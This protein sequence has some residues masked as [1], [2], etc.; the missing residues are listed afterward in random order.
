VTMHPRRIAGVLML[1]CT[2][3]LSGCTVSTDESDVR[4]I[5]SDIAQLL[6]PS[7]TPTPS[8]SAPLARTLV[9]WVRGNVY[10]RTPR[11]LPANSR[12]EQLDLALVELI[13]AGPRPTEAER[14]LESAIPP[15][16]T[17][18]GTVRG[19]RVVL[20]VPD[21]SQFEQGGVEEA[22]GQ[23]AIT[24]LSVPNVAS[25]RFTIDGAGTTV[26]VPDDR[27]SQ[28]VVTL[29]DYRTVLRN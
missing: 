1:T 3:A 24:A 29:A 28:R 8:E 27:R 12:Q 11:L 26:P 19:D 20:D 13:V 2:L 10:V 7:A 6:T 15:G 21:D 25:V 5:D 17:V 9:T 23:L 16:L 18:A 14:G 4:P 22:V